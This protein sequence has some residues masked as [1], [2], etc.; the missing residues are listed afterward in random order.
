MWLPGYE[1]IVVSTKRTG[2]APRGGGSPGRIVIHTTEGLRL[3]DYPY[4]PHFT[5]GLAGDPHSLP[6]KSYW[7]PAGTVTLKP[8]EQV[9]HQHCDLNLTSYALLHRSGDPETNHRG[10]HCVQVEIV[11]MAATPPKWSDGMYGLAAGWLA[12]VVTAVPE[13]RPALDNWPNK[14]SA[15]GSWGFTTP[16]R[17]SWAEWRDGINGRPGVPF[18]C[19]H[20][21]VPGNDHWDPGALDVAKL[22]RMAKAILDEPAP[23]GRPW[24]LRIMARL[25]AAEEAQAAA[26]QRIGRLERRLTTVEAALPK[27]EASRWGAATERWRPLVAKHFK[28][29]DVK[30]AL[31]LI[32]CESV[33]DPNAISRKKWTV[34]PAGWTEATADEWK[35]KGLFQH[36]PRYWPERA[37][38][39]GFPGASIFDPE[40]NIAAAAWLV[41]HTPN[42]WKH[43]SGAWA[44]VD[45]CLE[46]AEK[47][48]A[49]Q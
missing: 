17:M 4:P 19:G 23:G 13:L 22:T 1:K 38:A 45:G 47:Q 34:K 46:W 30:K 29:E 49:E 36:L 35:A 10:S 25:K 28:P 40:A 20:Q 41:Y 11:S 42:G 8:G 37:T 2:E 18:L 14:W 24:R 43:W 26:A 48:L 15:S 27:A 31:G 7:T 5:L 12:D 32:R 16:Y 44:G 6:A 9:K 33:G 39:A 3:Y 21:H